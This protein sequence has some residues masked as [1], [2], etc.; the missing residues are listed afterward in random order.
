[1]ALASER[2]ARS[3]VELSLSPLFHYQYSSITDGIDRLC[4]RSDRNELLRSFQNLCLSELGLP[5]LTQRGYT[6]LQ[7]DVTPYPKVHSPTLPNRGYIFKANQDLASQKPVTVGYDLSYLNLSDP[8]SGWSLPLDISRV[9]PDQNA[10]Q[11]LLAQLQGLFDQ[12][13][14]QQGRLIVN[15]LDSKYG[16][17][18]YL[19]PAYGYSSLVNVVRLSQGKKVYSKPEEGKHSVYGK[20]HYLIPERRIKTFANH[21]VTG[22]D[23]DVEQ[24]SIFE[25]AADEELTLKHFTKK[26]RELRIELR[27]WNKMR[28]R[29]KNGHDM[30][31]KPFD[32]IAVQ[33]FDAQ[34]GQRLYKQDLYLVLTGKR[35][36]E[37]STEEGYNIYGFRYDIEPSFRF[38]KQRLHLTRYQTPDIEHLDHWLLIQQMTI[39]LL[40]LASSEVANTP[41][42]WQKYLPAEKNTEQLTRLSIAQTYRAAQRHFS[43]FDLSPFYP[44]KSK[45]GRPREVGESQP[46]R[47]R[48]PVMKKNK[49]KAIIPQKE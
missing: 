2:Q 1:M 6:L 33:V 13:Q 18:G 12:P 15:A 36:Q 30:K 16:N 24:G 44:Q 20:C 39:W 5:L 14:M 38:A 11:C 32:L 19:A 35:R 46:P 23:Y 22:E 26:G 43:T 49:K 40:Y 10:T 8:D 28:L 4:L 42:K 9:K 29:S 7:T 45:K 31:D 3:V 37:I 48:Y 27:R 34:H 17:A 25:Q 21:P 47:K 41:Q